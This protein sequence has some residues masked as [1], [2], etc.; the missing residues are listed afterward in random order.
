MYFL[1]KAWLT[2]TVENFLDTGLPDNINIEYSDLNTEWI[3]GNVSI[4]K[5]VIHFYSKDSLHYTK[6]KLEELSVLR[7]EYLPYITKKNIRISNVTLK[8]PEIYKYSNT[9]ISSIS[10]KSIKNPG[11]S[12]FNINE[13][14][15]QNG[16]ISVFEKPSNTLKLDIKKFNIK[17]TDFGTDN[18]TLLKKIPFRYHN[19]NAN[20]KKLNVILNQFDNLIIDDIYF[21]KNNVLAKKVEIKT[22][23]DKR[24]LSNKIQTERDHVYLSIPVLELYNYH[25]YSNNKGNLF[26]KAD[27]SKIKQPILELYRDKLIPDN[28]TYKP[29]YGKM[30]K[31][32]NFNIHIPKIEVIDGFVGYEEL[33]HY[34]TEA[35][36]IYFENINTSIALSSANKKNEN[37]K[38]NSSAVFMG[39]AAVALDLRFKTET[40]QDNF[41]ASGSFKNFTS[42]SINSFL[43]NNLRSRA[44]GKVSEAYFTISGNDKRSIGDMKMKYQDFEFVILKKD[45]LKINKTFT[46]LANLLVNDGSKTDSNGYRFGKIE[47]ERDQT[48]SFFNFLWIS[49]RDGLKDVVAGNGKK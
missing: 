32:L 24:N 11:F 16:K 33:V 7:F 38:I 28:K 40:T 1:I 20:F 13:L 37:I 34:H 26:F 12:S 8:E 36:R 44:K 27:S 45:A 39:E 19:I 23:Y 5:P 29:L 48:K 22:K 6:I 35:G 9:N 25:Y 2:I 4:Q 43:E 14:T 30:L 15:I 10:K 42:K 21:D 3:N 18:H 46:A 31:Q 41:T 49:I 17:I 47:I